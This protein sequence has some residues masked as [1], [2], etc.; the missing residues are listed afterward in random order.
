MRRRTKARECTLQILYQIE[1][2]RELWESACH[3]YWEDHPVLE[4][5]KEFATQLVKGVCENRESI[6]QWICRCAENW[7]LN[8]MAAVDR[9]I[10]RLASYEL[11][12]LKEIP[13]KVSINEAVELAKKYGD[14]DSSKF[15][16]GILDR[17]YKDNENDHR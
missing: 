11:R 14:V 17:I 9:N 7:E 12:Y 15:V 2:S 4:E 1:I 3:D 5:I 13:P 6:D 8:R 16:N 10:L